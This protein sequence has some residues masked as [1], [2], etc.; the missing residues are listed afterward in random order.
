MIRPKI[1]YPSSHIIESLYTTGKE[2]Q[3][4]SGTEYIGFYHKYIDG[5]V[6]TEATYNST[7]SKKLV[8]YIDKSVQPDN[9]QYNSLIQEKS[10][11]LTSPYQYYPIPKKGDEKITRYFLKQRNSQEIIEINKDQYGL[12][13]QNKID[14]ALYVAIEL[15]WKLTGIDVYEKNKN[16]VE[17]K[18]KEMNGLTNFL[19]DY[20]ELT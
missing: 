20:L 17:L 11:E 14:R 8:K 2:Y 4:E 6:A 7:T 10:K 19:T 15:D 1:Y 9:Y 3:L 12:W 18:N 16:T 13:K 5:F